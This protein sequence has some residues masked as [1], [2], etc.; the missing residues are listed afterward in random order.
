MKF[1]KLFGCGLLLVSLCSAMEQK[2]DFLDAIKTGNIEFVRSAIAQD[3]SLLDVTMMG[4]TALV[5]A[6][7]KWAK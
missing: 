1:L 3:P 7:E 5:I 6:I 2:R 4:R